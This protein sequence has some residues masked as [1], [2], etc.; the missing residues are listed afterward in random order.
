MANNVFA[1]TGRYHVN[2]N[3]IE[4]IE[5]RAEGRTA[6]F[7]DGVEVDG[8]HPDFEQTL[9]S[10]IP[11]PPDMEC[12]TPF[13]DPDDDSVTVD[14]EPL[15]A[16]GFTVYGYTVPVI[17]SQPGGHFDEYALRKVGTPTVYAGDQRFPDESTWLAYRKEIKSSLLRLVAK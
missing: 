11:A 6:I 14:I 3:R 15:I 5:R 7:V 17:P 2:L 8:N 16:L 10:I 12:L 13:D 1:Y 4:K 9:S